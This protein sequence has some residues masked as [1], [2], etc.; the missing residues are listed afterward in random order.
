MAENINNETNYYEIAYKL[1]QFKS[2]LQNSIDKNNVISLQYELMSFIFS[3][4][5]LTEIFTQQ[6]NNFLKISNDEGFKELIG[7]IH[8]FLA[9]KFYN[10]S[11]ESLSFDVYYLDANS[12]LLFYPV[13]PRIR[14]NI[15]LCNG[16]IHFYYQNFRETVKE[17]FSKIRLE[18]FDGLNFYILTYKFGTNFLGVATPNPLSKY[19]SYWL[20]SAMNMVI[21][22]FQYMLI[23][24]FS[25]RYYNEAYNKFTKKIEEEQK[26]KNLLNNLSP[27]E[28][29]V[30]N[31][32]SKGDTVN[33]IACLRKCSKSTIY[34]HLTHCNQK[35]KLKD[36]TIPT[37]REFIAQYRN[38]L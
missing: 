6:V 30:F 18:K 28:R 35:L 37:L 25:N 2:R 19:H 15:V 36:N 13:S 14:E 7:L 9:A 23:N 29:E 31:T 21:D 38:L 8:Q 12:T 17:L 5:E 24:D 22:T 34:D 3:S 26:I 11:K 27:T 16:I 4:E 32:F 1:E 20:A 33:A 10:Y